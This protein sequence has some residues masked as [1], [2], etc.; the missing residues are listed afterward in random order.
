MTD[1]ERFELWCRFVEQ[2]L[3][4]PALGGMVA[5]GDPAVL[6]KSLGVC[7]GAVADQLFKHACR[8]FRAT[9]PK[10][11]G[12]VSEANPVAATEAPGEKP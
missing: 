5:S 11:L 2:V 9:Q 7:A 4:S 12:D 10:D 1:K 3:A 6:G 8:G